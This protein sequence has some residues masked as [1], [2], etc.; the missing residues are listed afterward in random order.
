MINLDKSENWS[1]WADWVEAKKVH[2]G[3]K[4]GL[5]VYGGIIN[6]DPDK[7]K[8]LVGGDKITYDEYLDLQMM[9][10]E[11]KGG[12]RR[13]FAMCYYYIPL[14]FMGEIERIT[15]KAVCFKRIY[16][17]GMYPDGTCFDGK[18]DHVWIDKHGI[19]GYGIGDCLSFFA[20][21]Y[22]YIKT[23][24]G[25]QID[26]GLRNPQGIKIIEKYELPSD[27]ELM[28]QSI[29]AII[30]ETCYLNEQVYGGM[31]LRDKKERQ[32]LRKDM[33]KA[34]KGS[35]KKRRNGNE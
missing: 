5:Q 15:R 28:L 1:S 18:E 6:F 34:V 32:S 10:C 4:T 9:A 13:D 16:V 35:E 23:G 31:C 11:N 27:E 25:K 33:F 22:R 29:D 3:S 19:E 7:Q 8:D 21:P 14:E 26:F 30:C 20:E 12:V 17:S 2:Y 24:N